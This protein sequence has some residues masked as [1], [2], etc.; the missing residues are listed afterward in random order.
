MVPEYRKHFTSTEKLV[1]CKA[2]DIYGIDSEASITRYITAMYS[3]IHPKRWK[4]IYR[5]VL[6][7]YRMH[8]YTSPVDFCEDLRFNAARRVYAEKNRL[9]SA[10]LDG[11]CIGCVETSMEHNW[12]IGDISKPKEEPNKSTSIQELD[13]KQL[14]STVDPHI[15][16]QHVYAMNKQSTKDCI[17]VLR[18][19][20]K[21]NKCES[22]PNEKE[23]KRTYYVMSDEERE[24]DDFMDK[25]EEGEYTTASSFEIP[26]NKLKGKHSVIKGIADSGTVNTIKD[27]KD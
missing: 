7:T 20:Q 3:Y 6:D 26:P 25:L 11:Q 14:C 8:G 19:P 4:Q 16:K 5:D 9:R 17:D 18:S 2:V 10:I 22:V 12:N 13:D 23:K 21:T 27:N 24:F 15:M 1:V